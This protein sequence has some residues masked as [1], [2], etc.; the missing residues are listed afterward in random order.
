MNYEVFKGLNLEGRHYQGVDPT[1][2]K[3]FVVKFDQTICVQDRGQD[4]TMDPDTC[5]YCSFP[6]KNEKCQNCLKKVIYCMSCS[7]VIKSQLKQVYWG[8]GRSDPR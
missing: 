5:L 2:R 1:E 4:L 7:E 8:D 3:H 6:T